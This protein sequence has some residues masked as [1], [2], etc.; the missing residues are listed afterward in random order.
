VK[1]KTESSAREE[2]F[3]RTV[4]FESEGARLTADWIMPPDALG[5]VLFAHGSGSSRHS[6]RNKMVARH[7]V[8]RGMG[9]F[10]LDLLTPDEEQ[11]DSV[12]R[13]LRFNIPFLGKRLVEATRWLQD[14]SESR[15]AP[16][17]YFG[18]STGSAAALVAAAG[19]K[20]SIAAIVSRGGRPDLAEHA[21]PLV[22]APT[23][24]LVGGNDPEVEDL[25]REAMR[26][27]VWPKELV[28]IP[29]AT[30]LFEEPGTLDQVAVLAANWFER[31]C[32]AWKQHG[33]DSK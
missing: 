33:G 24:L 1:T 10:L 6:S 3:A 22:S 19:M 17:G 9:S 29:G 16:L 4:H 20:H 26:R 5:I 2:W 21:L 15:N 8:Q 14:Q 13:H 12:T 32:L 11:V 25:N 7:L 18:A 28:I 30:H 27:M 23:L 31:H